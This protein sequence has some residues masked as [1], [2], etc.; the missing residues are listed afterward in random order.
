MHLLYC[1]RNP[2][3]ASKTLSN[4]ADK[5]YSVYTGTM[6][7]ILEL[8]I[9]KASNLPEAA[10]ERLGRELLERI[11]ALEHLRTEIEAGLRELDGAWVKRS[12]SRRSSGKPTKSMPKK[13][14]RVI[15][16]P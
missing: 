1:R 14:R 3:M 5:P 12:T 15:W 9:R 7:K 2:P 13:R 8:A 4:L 10:Q 6:V 16:S 11:E